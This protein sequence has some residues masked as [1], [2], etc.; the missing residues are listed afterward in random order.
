MSVNVTDKEEEAGHE[1]LLLGGAS[2]LY[3]SPGNIYVTCPDWSGTSGE[4]SIHRI[5]VD[6]GKIEYHATGQV[7]GSLLNQFSLDENG[8]YLRV[9]TTVWDWQSSGGER[10]A[11][12]VY[13][14]D[15]ALD[16]FGRLENVAPD[17]TIHSARFMGDRCYLVTFEQIDPLFVIDLAD[18]GRPQVLGELVMPGYSDYLHPYDQNHL[19]GIGMLD[20]RVK[21]S[22]YDVT[23]PARPKEMSTFL[24]GEGGGDRD[25]AWS[26]TYT[27]VL[28]DHRALLFDRERG[29]MVLPVSIENAEIGSGSPSWDPAASYSASR[30]QGAYVFDVSLRGGLKL[31]GRIS[32]YAGPGSDYESCYRCAIKRSLY[33]GQVLYTISDQQIGLHHLE[34]LAEIGEITLAE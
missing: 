9:A 22:L 19:I 34:T 17:E 8:E 29:L 28:D 31:A 14:L 7:P 12:S 2:T 21:I 3:V 20:S 23:N 13:V 4:T 16:I 33:I 18:P 15:Q 10:R 1:T 24:A 32:H 25:G 26:Y 27:A 11:N 30:W 6:Q 5:H